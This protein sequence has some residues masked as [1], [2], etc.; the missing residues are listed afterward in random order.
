MGQGQRGT[1]Q[2]AEL[3][4]GEGGRR[5]LDDALEDGGTRLLQLFLAGAFGLV[6]LL[7]PLFFLSALLLFLVC[8]AL[9]FVAALTPE[10]KRT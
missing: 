2:D 10:C 3:S 6:F 1:E 4:G 9:L 8:L 5:I 7:S